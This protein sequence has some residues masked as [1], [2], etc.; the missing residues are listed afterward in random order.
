MAFLMT[1]LSLIIIL[2]TFK[3]QTLPERKESTSAI[4]RERER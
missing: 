4:E 3:Y 2:I 1:I